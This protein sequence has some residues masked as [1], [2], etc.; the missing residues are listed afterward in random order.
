M[1]NYDAIVIGSGPAGQK[2]A[3]ASAKLGKKAVLIEGWDIGGSSLHTATIP[4]KTLR[5]SILELTNYQNRG[6][7]TAQNPNSS[8]GNI[9]MT[10]LHHRINWVKSHLKATITHQLKKNGIEILNGHGRFIDANTVEVSMR[11]GEKRILKGDKI[12]LSTGSAPRKPKHIPFDGSK[13]L[14]STDFLS[15]D[16]IPKSMIIVGAGIIGCEYASMMCVLGVKVT[17]IDR[18]ASLLP[19]LDKEIGLHLQVAL[20]EHN[21][22]FLCQK[23]FKEIKTTD[24]GVEITL[25]DGEVIKAERA[26]IASGR[27][28][29]VKHLDI[30]K[31]G[32]KVDKKGYISVSKNFQTAQENIYAVGDV[33][34]G[35]CLASTAYLQGMLAANCAFSNNVCKTMNEFPVG[36]YTIP[37]ISFVGETEESL[38]EKQVPYEVGRAYFYEISRCII[39]GNKTGM[40]KLLFCRKNFTL[41]GAHIIGRGAT[42]VIH[43]A[44]LAISLNAKIYYFVDHVFNF[45][46]Y[47]EMYALAARN[48][49]NKILLQEK[50]NEENIV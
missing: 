37:E 14:T 8:R 31:A 12:F 13:V 18:H 21:L 27:E 41:L 50:K 33:V 29:N 45:P 28:A 38:R 2:A 32:I 24:K 6:F 20:E 48:G 15:M 47:A 17:L 7:Y 22:T 23:E 49:I 42:E 5:E 9:S 40:C 1:N 16:T 4:S 35:P 43:I 30:E 36:I 39:T 46:T 11:D 26:L 34:G 10:D 25:S 44:Q 19:F 3:I